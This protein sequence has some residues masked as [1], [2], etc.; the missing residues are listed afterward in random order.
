VTNRIPVLTG[1][2]RQ[3]AVGAAKI[4]NVEEIDDVVDSVA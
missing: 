3:E 2:W 4:V 1:G